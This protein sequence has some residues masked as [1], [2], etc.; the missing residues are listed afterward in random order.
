MRVFGELRRRNV[1]KVSVAYVLLSWLLVRLV[2]TLTSVPGGGDR[3]GQILTMALILGFP[4]IVLFAWA[5]EITPQ[6][7]KP[8]SGVDKTQSITADTGRRLNYI[9]VG[10]LAL[11][12]A[13]IVIEIFA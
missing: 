9:L 1:F 4:I 8:T 5:Y 11:A 6:G 13:A 2:N 12:A 7:L 10:L 3:I